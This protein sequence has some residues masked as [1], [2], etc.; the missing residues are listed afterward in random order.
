VMGALAATA[1]VGYAAMTPAQS[2]W[3]LAPLNLIAL[4]AQSALMPLG[5]TVTLA[6]SRSDGLDYRRIRVWGS[7]SFILGS[8]ASGA[9]LAS[10][11]AEQALPLVLS[12]FALLLMACLC[13]PQLRHPTGGSR[14]AGVRAFA[15]E[16][17]FWIFVVVASALHQVYWPTMGRGCRCRNPAVL[18]GSA[19]AR[20]VWADR[21]DGAWRRRGDPTLEPIEPMDRAAVH[22]CAAAAARLDIGASHLGAMYFRSRTVRPT[23][24][25]SAQ[26]VYAA[27]SSGLGSGLVMPLADA[28]YADYGRRAYLF[29]AALSAGFSAPSY[30]E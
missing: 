24:S 11:S 2:F 14:F 28:L 30:S 29:M 25:A 27:V 26:S 3:V 9:A 4:T 6:V 13:T 18:A 10:S 7:V 12:A 21:V 1:F 19:P 16:R 20:P 5:D 17:R 22:R 15:G 8:L 23:A